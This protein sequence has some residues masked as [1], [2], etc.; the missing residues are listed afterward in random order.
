MYIDKATYCIGTLIH[1]NFC[2]IPLKNHA[3]VILAYL[4]PEHIL[5]GKTSDC[6]VDIFSRMAVS[7]KV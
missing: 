3:K 1:K 7:E 5:T 6:H 2:T 4:L